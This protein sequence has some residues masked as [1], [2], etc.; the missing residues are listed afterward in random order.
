M[1]VAR[2]Y[3]PRVNTG[4][5][6]CGHS[7]DSPRLELP[8][9]STLKARPRVL[10]RLQEEIRQYYRSPSRLPSLNAANKSK[11]QQRSE[12][13]E[14]CLLALSAILEFTDLSSLRCGIPTRE[15]FVSLTI[16][17]LVKFTGMGLR[18]MERALADLKQANILTISQP[19]QLNEDGSWRG[20]AA[21]KAVSRHLFTAFGL[22]RW[23]KHERDRAAARLHKKTKKQGGTLTQWARNH[24]VV[25]GVVKSAGRRHDQANRLQVTAGVDR[26]AYS[27][28]RNDLL[29]ALYQERPGWK[30][31]ELNAEVDRLLGTRFKA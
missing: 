9:A 17:F 11:R 30:A 24:L 14:A 8:V 28:A 1:H 25:G 2:T 15:G 7:P 10:A 18:R 4:G 23:L 19:R 12:R 16:D 31:E 22:A 26:E 27:R 5:N 29:M 21:V 20:L 6:F 13:R 3:V